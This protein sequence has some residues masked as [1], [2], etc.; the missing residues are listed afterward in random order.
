VRTVE[1]GN[2]R[3]DRSAERYK[4]RLQIMALVVAT[5]MMK[6]NRKVI[7]SEEDQL[8]SRA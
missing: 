1:G 6:T 2:T 4:D 5:T 7:S 3:I 8:S